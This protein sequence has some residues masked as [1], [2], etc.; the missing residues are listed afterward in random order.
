M[1]KSY[2]I[3]LLIGKGGERISGFLTALSPK[4]GMHVTK[5]L[6]SS[7]THFTFET[8]QENSPYKYLGPHPTC[9]PSMKVTKPSICDI[10]YFLSHAMHS[11]LERNGYSCSL[12]A[13]LRSHVTSSTYRIQGLRLVDTGTMARCS[14][15]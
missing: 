11:P 2:L 15:S 1:G 10:L 9:S 8:Q 13:H 3:P 7:L 5:T 4:L 6:F 12:P 14:C